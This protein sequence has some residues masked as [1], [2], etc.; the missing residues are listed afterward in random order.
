MVMNLCNEFFS[1]INFI[2]SCCIIWLFRKDY[3]EYRISNLKLSLDIK[4]KICEHTKEFKID[5]SITVVDISNSQTLS[6]PLG[7][8]EFADLYDRGIMVYTSFPKDVKKLESKWIVTS[9]TLETKIAYPLGYIPYTSIKSFDI[10]PYNERSKYIFYC[11]FNNFTTW[12]GSDPYEKIRYCIKHEY[13]YDDIGDIYC[14]KSKFKT[15]WC[16]LKYGVISIFRVIK[17]WI[18][19]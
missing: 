1:I 8:I 3:E 17:S 4:N 6:S 18:L 5:N 13:H 15:F 14:F 12:Y 19:W 2:A 11:K 7:I 16:K 10:N 9:K